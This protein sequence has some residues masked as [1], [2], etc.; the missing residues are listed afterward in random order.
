[1]SRIVCPPLE[2]RGVRTAD[3]WKA[4]GLSYSQQYDELFA[5]PMDRRVP[6]PKP[7]TAAQAREPAA[8]RI[9][10]SNVWATSKL[11]SANCVAPIV[12]HPRSCDP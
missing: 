4:E 12:P 8:R 9:P 10:F 5:G 2:P 3:P 1:M 7:S 11:R 6:L